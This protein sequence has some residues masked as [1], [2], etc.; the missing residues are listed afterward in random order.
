MLRVCGCRS[1]PTCSA[2]IGFYS[3]RQ[4]GVL[5]SRLTNDVQALDQ[6]VSDA[7]VTLFSRRLTLIGAS[8]ILYSSTW[9]SPCS[10][11][12][13]CRVI[14]DRLV[15][16]VV[17][18]DAY[19]ATRETIGEHSA[20]LQETLSGVRVVRAFGR[21]AAPRGRFSGLNDANRAANMTT[22]NLNA[23][24]FPA[25]ELASAMATIACC[26]TAACR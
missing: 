16:R 9:R 2:S 8:A 25:V 17:A 23:A 18:A 1:S 15:F 20:E 10:G 5:I 21:G 12:S 6:L 26:S 19:S 22:V 11:S 3:R 4:T 24:Y 14:W 13:S 7:V